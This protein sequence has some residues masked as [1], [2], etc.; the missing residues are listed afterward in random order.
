MKLTNKYGC[1]HEIYNLVVYLRS[2][3]SSGDSD[4]S[5]TGL[6]APS[7]IYA[8]EKKYK[9]VLVV[10]VADVMKMAIGSGVHW[11]LERFALPGA[12]VEQRFFINVDGYKISAQIDNLTDGVLTDWKTAKAT[13]FLKGYPVKKEYAAQMNI[14]L[15]CLRQ[16]GLD[17]H[18][19]LI[20]GVLLDHDPKRARF[21]EKY[22][23]APWSSKEV[24]IWPREKTMEFIRERIKSHK[25]ALEEL[26]LCKP[27][28]VWNGLRCEYFC[29]INNNN[30]CEQYNK[31]KQTGL[32][33]GE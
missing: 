10:D 3:Y 8:L 33:K 14:Q 9:D 20:E 21:E 15:E 2:L 26:P 12:I 30:L 24:K 5:A 4:F 28:E 29:T 16:N 7:R 22:P 13:A 32:L 1:R 19:L 23:I 25:M 17:A 11:G 6:I 31:A 27:S 18:K